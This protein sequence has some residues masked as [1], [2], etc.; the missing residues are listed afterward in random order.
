MRYRARSLACFVLLCLTL[1]VLATFQSTGAPTLA[2]KDMSAMTNLGLNN[3]ITSAAQVGFLPDELLVSASNTLLRP[4]YEDPLAS[5]TNLTNNNNF[6]ESGVDSYQDL[7]GYTWQH[8]PELFGMHLTW[9]SKNLYGAINMIV[10]GNGANAYVLFDTAPSV[11]VYDFTDI[12]PWKRQLKFSGIRPD[13]FLGLYSDYVNNSTLWDPLQ[14]QGYL[15]AK[16]GSDSAAICGY[17][18]RY[19]TALGKTDEVTWYQDGINVYTNAKR[20]WAGY[21]GRGKTADPLN[22]D[23]LLFFKIPWSLLLTRASNDF[24]GLTNWKIKLCVATTGPQDSSKMWD[25]LP[26]SRYAIK[27]ALD[28]GIDAKQNNYFEI[29]VTDGSGNFRY[30]ADLQAD[31]KINFYPGSYLD[32]ANDPRGQIPFWPVNDAGIQAKGFAPHLAS[33]IYFRL[34]LKYN[35]ILNCNLKVYDIK[36]N[37][38]RTIFSGKA[39][40]VEVG[41]QNILFNDNPSV[42]P[43]N[44]LSWDGRTDSGDIAPMGIYFIVFKGEDGTVEFTRKLPF[45]LL[46]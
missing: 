38:V 6:C 8:Q 42:T 10:Q 3:T 19:I 13:C 7:T 30:P 40:E 21:T 14:T 17:Q 25:W 31:A 44:D 2:D 28:L 26:D 46:K 23:N 39:F 9:D 43:N 1:L 37:V 12:G 18:F 36:G 33:R 15:K 45:M 41:Q 24:I 22:T 32:I 35:S 34:F 27:K 5:E 29:Q 20:P 16:T 4:Y 11:G